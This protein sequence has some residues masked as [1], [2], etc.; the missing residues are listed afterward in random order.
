MLLFITARLRLYL[1]HPRFL[2]YFFIAS[3][4]CMEVLLQLYHCAIINLDL[5]LS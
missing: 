2:F 3:S 5:F 1:L 4:L